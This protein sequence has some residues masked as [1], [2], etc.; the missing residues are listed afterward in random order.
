M[1]TVDRFHL[2]QI[3]NRELDDARKAEKARA[4]K[5]KNCEKRQQVEAS[6]KSSKYSILTY[7]M[8]LNEKESQKLKQ[9]QKVSPKLAKMHENKEELRNI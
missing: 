7:E 2:M 6:L 9:V 4:K 3:V 5:M 8:D 1:I